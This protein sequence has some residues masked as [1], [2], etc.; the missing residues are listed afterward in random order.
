ME[1]IIETIINVLCL[2]IG[3]KIG[4]KATK[5]EELTIPTPTKIIT[6]IKENRERKMEEEL[7]AKIL[8][9]IDNYNGTSA[10]QKDL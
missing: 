2:L 9:N 4:Q 5:G 1:S 7:N 6:E 3:V 10:G 8:E